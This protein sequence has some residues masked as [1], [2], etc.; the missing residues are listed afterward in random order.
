MTPQEAINKIDA[1]LK[2]CE[3]CGWEDTDDPEPVLRACREALS[4]VS[5]IPIEQET[6]DP[7]DEVLGWQTWV[8]EA[9][10]SEGVWTCHR[11]DKDR[12]YCKAGDWYST[13]GD[14]L[15]NITHWMPVPQG[16]EAKP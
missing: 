4:E 8:P 6:P 10:W 15:P 13:D 11:W 3:A 2:S 16:P 5:W 14:K 12:E 7:K 9:Y 1:Y